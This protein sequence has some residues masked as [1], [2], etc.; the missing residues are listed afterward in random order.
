MAWYKE[1]SRTARA[2]RRWAWLALVSLL[3]GAS[4][5]AERLVLQVDMLGQ[6]A[7]VEVDTDMIEPVEGRGT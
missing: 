4:A 6:A 5:H 2:R 1:H 7:S 3:A